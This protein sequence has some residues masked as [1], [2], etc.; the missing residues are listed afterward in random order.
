MDCEHENLE[1]K[2]FNMWACECGEEFDIEKGIIYQLDRIKYWNYEN[3][4]LLGLI[5][6]ELRKEESDD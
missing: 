1:K 6:E 2:G 4:K 3:H 5:L